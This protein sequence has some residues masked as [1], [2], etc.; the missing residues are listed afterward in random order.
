MFRE[1]I[2]ANTT[3]TPGN[4][5]EQHILCWQTGL[6]VEARST[7]TAGNI[8]SI[9]SSFCSIVSVDLYKI[10]SR[11]LGFGKQPAILSTFRNSYFEPL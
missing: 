8:L 5:S 10:T 6:K 3:V 1:V 11:Y 4:D 2:P 9:T 7:A